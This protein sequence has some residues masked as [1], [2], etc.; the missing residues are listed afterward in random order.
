[1]A[2]FFFIII[3]A[4]IVLYV[5]KSIWEGANATEMICTDCGS[6]GAGKYLTK[7]NILIEI[8]LWLCLIIPG[9]IYSIWRV[10]SNAKVCSR[11]QGKLIRV[12][13][14]RGQQLYKQFVAK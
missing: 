10:S 2:G 11:C 9:L 3:I 6:I 14:P 1:M 5:V 8:I 13:S 4:A 12:D 7:G